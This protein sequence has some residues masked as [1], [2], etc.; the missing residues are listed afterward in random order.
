MG[1]VMRRTYAVSSLSRALLRLFHRSYIG[2]FY[3]N[4][5]MKQDSRQSVS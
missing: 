5:L 2:K 3:R 4:Y 1:H